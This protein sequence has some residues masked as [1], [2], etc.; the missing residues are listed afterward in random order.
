MVLNTSDLVVPDR[1]LVNCLDPGLWCIGLSKTVSEGGGQPKPS[2]A[3]RPQETVSRYSEAIKETCARAFSTH[4]RPG[5][6][7]FS[8]QQM[9][10]IV[11]N[12]KVPF[13]FICPPTSKMFTP[14]PPPFS[15]S[16][17]LS[18]IITSTHCII[19]FF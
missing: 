17:Y 4:L 10:N 7:E 14:V 13:L 16:Y 19:Y 8:I 5:I 2:P 9:E 1:G 12:T 3:L 15:F 18:P 11:P 6:T